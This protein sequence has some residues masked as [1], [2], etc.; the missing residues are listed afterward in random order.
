MKKPKA[1]RAY[2]LDID[3]IQQLEKYCA[4]QLIIN[5]GESTSMHFHI[6]KHET[7]IVIAGKLRIEY[8]HKKKVHAT[9]LKPYDSFV[10]APGLPHKLKCPKSEKEPTRIIEC[11]TKHYNDDSIRIG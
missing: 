4:K 5:P 1:I 6:D 11:S 7:M 10:I 9:E 8:I 3:L 2:S